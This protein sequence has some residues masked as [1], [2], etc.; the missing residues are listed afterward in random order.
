MA[1]V[2]PAQP[3]PLV[4]TELALLQMEPAVPALALEHPFSL[5]KFWGLYSFDGWELVHVRNGIKSVVVHW[6]IPHP[7]VEEYGEG[8]RMTLKPS[9]KHFVGKCYIGTLGHT[10]HSVGDVVG[11]V[12]R[13]SNGEAVEHV[14][15][16]SVRM[17]L[18]S[19]ETYDIFT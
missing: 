10:H 6:I 1:T 3:V 18:V 12:E 4:P 11:K 5:L 13:F 8:D 17:V 15:Q 2:E 7:L 9:E 19:S 14:A 16:T